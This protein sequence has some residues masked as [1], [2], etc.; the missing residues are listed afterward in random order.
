LKNNRFENYK[1]INRNY[2]L[3]EEKPE[4]KYGM[5][6]QTLFIHRKLSHIFVVKNKINIHI[7]WVVAFLANIIF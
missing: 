6:F 3:Q 7:L 4:V 2:G 5:S 1:N